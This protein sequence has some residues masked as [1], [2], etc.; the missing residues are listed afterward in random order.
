MNTAN[1]SNIP[2]L[3][4]SGE[5]EFI[6][7]DLEL[8]FSKRQLKN[9]VSQWNYGRS[10]EKIAEINSRNEHEI[11]LALY[12]QARKENIN[13]PFAYRMGGGGIK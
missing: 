5:H 11:F 1:T 10:I 6:L 4:R 7:E 2:L 3:P 9:I 8:V 13:R 12:D